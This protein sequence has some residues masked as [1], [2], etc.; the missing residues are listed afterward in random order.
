MLSEKTLEQS[1]DFFSQVE[2]AYNHKT[3]D[4]IRYQIIENLKKINTIINYVED[5]SGLNDKTAI[6]HHEL[7]EIKNKCVVIE[8][9]ADQLN[10]KFS[11][12]IMGSG[13]NG[14][15][16][17]INALLGQ[18]KAAVNILPQTWK[19]DIYSSSKNDFVNLRYKDGKIKKITTDEAE[20]IIFE[21]EQ[22]QKESQK[23]IRSI[24]KEFKSS[25]ATVEQL[26]DMKRK[27]EKYDLYKSDITEAVWPVNGSHILEDYRL[28][29]TPGLK[30]E[31]AS[32]MIISDSMDYY[33]K[34]DGV[35]WL[36]PADKIA[37]KTDYEE[38]KLLEANKRLRKGNVIAVI[39]KID[40]VS[41]KEKEILAEANKLYGKI[42][43][44]FVPVSAKKAF[45]AHKI[46][47]KAEKGSSQEAE[48]LNSLKDSGIPNLIQYL[49]QTMFADALDIQLQSKEVSINVT[50][51][52][53]ICLVANLQNVL[54][55]AIKK[56]KRLEKK[57]KTELDEEKEGLKADLE[58]LIS[59]EGTR[60]SQEVAAVEDA[61]WEMESDERSEYI[62]TRI[63]RPEQL[64]RS[65][66]S[67]MRKHN[68]RL[69]DLQKTFVVKSA[70]T[71]F[72]NLSSNQLTTFGGCNSLVYT[73]YLDNLTS[74]D[75]AQIALMG[76]LAIGA[77]A[78]LGPIGIL[79]AGI[80]A[81]N[82]GRSIA[83][84]FSRT[85]GDSLAVKTRRNFNS[86]MADISDKITNDF[87][88]N[89]KKSTEAVKNVRDESFA[90]LYGSYYNQEKI[91]NSLNEIVCL[92]NNDIKFLSVEDVIFN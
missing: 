82:T 57:W 44:V 54:E 9:L 40:M 51:E 8:E 59:T 73:T 80:A 49:Q 17:L 79:A 7:N 81:T 23:N 70:F 30:Q 87:S 35:I 29:D 65:F 75:G 21:E 10:E 11:L 13:K 88:K 19:I 53:V 18:E 36:L 20:K 31:I 71:E 69:V 16:T 32:E 28:V 48:A 12:F 61:L 90:M 52:E 1:L 25:G 68:Q 37:S 66:E 64:K 77:T 38:I 85:F 34:A 86:S 67:I 24:V 58:R 46:I 5:Q 43:D 26:E 41:G 91:S 84:F 15:S 83:K 78:L 4:Y 47:S 22:K 2:S 89:S 42:F 3:K 62:Q 33:G 76:A 6:L 92:C 45:D 63:I 50:Y 74:E 55:E 14:K 60:I 56:Y 27:L 39:N 72:P